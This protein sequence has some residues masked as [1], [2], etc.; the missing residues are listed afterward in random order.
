MYLPAVIF[1][2]SLSS[3]LIRA[4]FYILIIVAMQ[5]VWAIEFLSTYPTQYFHS[6]YNFSRTLGR[7]ASRNYLW[8]GENQEKFFESALFARILMVLTLL[9]WLYF[10][11]VR[12]VPLLHKRK[13]FSIKLLFE[14]ISF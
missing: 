7:T 5:G 11:I 10:L 14:N 3:G 2:V 1:V 12:W 9:T 13:T 8:I 6:A 4:I